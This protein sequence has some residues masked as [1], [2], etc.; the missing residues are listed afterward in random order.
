MSRVDVL[1]RVM[2]RTALLTDEPVVALG[3]GAAIAPCPDIELA[4]CCDEPAAF[5]ERLKNTPAEVTI[6]DFTPKIPFEALRQLNETAPQTKVVL[7]VRRLSFEMGYQAV[8]LGVRGIIEKTASM[9]LLLSC[10]RAVGEGKLWIE[11]QLIVEFLA[12]RTISLSRREKQLLQLV[13]LGLR[14]KEIGAQLGIT[15]GTVKVYFSRLFQKLGVRDRYELALYG[16][17]YANAWASG[18]TSGLPALEA[19][20]AGEVGVGPLFVRREG[21]VVQ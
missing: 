1:V 19:A 17:Q 8:A 13:S 12:A 18:G 21:R 7:W 5:S 9:D 15:E 6:V 20:V 10:L 2:L 14:N 4:F 16:L 11:Q 3:L